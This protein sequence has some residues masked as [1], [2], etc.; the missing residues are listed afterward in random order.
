MTQARE[1]IDKCLDKSYERRSSFLQRYQFDVFLVSNFRISHTNS[2][3]LYNAFKE[4]SFLK[5]IVS[6]ASFCLAF[7]WTFIIKGEHRILIE[8]PYYKQK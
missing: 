5:K 7:I 8:S 2:I 6:V 4:M 1:G 3:K